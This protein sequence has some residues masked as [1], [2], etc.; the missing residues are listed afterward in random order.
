MTQCSCAVDDNVVL[1][2]LVMTGSPC[3]GM[4]NFFIYN[5]V[6]NTSYNKALSFNIR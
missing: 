4:G 6:N 1:F 2:H 3:S 5:S